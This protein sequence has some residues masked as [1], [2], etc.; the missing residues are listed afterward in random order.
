MNSNVSTFAAPG[1][2]RQHVFVSAA[3]PMTYSGKFTPP[4]GEA[5][6]LEEGAASAGTGAGLEESAASAAT[7]GAAT[8]GAASDATDV[9]CL[10]LSRRRFA[11]SASSSASAG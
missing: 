11:S 5:A 9:G 2:R 3:Q 1:S 10:K 7:E 4:V 6:W 8:E